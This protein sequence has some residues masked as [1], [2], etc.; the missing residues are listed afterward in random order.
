MVTG[1]TIWDLPWLHRAARSRSA[2]IAV[3]TKTALEVWDRVA[4]RKGLT[5]FPSPHTP[6]ENN[7]W[8]PPACH[9]LAFSKW[10]Q[11]GCRVIWDLYD[12]D[13]LKTWDH[14]R[15]EFCLPLG[16][17]LQYAQL[18]HWVAVPAM[19]RAATRP[20]T[21]FERLVHLFDGTRG[22]ISKIYQILQ[23]P[24][25][26]VTHP[27]QHQWQQLSPAD[28][29]PSQ[30]ARLWKDIPQVFRSVAQRENAYKIMTQWYYTPVRLQKMFPATSSLCWRCGTAPG[31]FLHI[32]WDCPLVTLLWKE[33]LSHIREVLGFPLPESAV[34]LLLGL[35]PESLG[36]LTGSDS[37]IALH[38]LG[39]AK[40]LI[41]LYWKKAETPPVAAWFV[42]LW[43]VI[44]MELLPA[45]L[46]GHPTRFG[47]IWQPLANYLCKIEHVRFLPSKLRALRLF[48]D[49]LLPPHPA[50]LNSPPDSC[51]P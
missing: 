25:L 45:H 2:Y 44:T 8:F 21:P 1:R 30:W 9:T 7:P 49:P 27:Y 42:R 6:I 43:H 48:E 10:A 51:S 35:K 4:A 23:H 19:S 14:C 50:Q 3:P 34:S 15:E 26:V 41:A 13:A 17:K 39:A 29:T 16:G 38:M 5:T 12:G 46:H 40:Q 18:R 33:V 22:L 32:W 24:P 20:F 47:T 31:D 11:G 37:T 36:A 28:I